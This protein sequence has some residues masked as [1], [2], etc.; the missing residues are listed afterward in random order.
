MNTRTLT[1][2][3]SHSNQS[4]STANE[5][6]KGSETSNNLETKDMVFSGEVVVV[7]FK[8]EKMTSIIGQTSKSSGNIFSSEGYRIDGYHKG[9]IEATTILVTQTG[10]VEG[11]ITA[12]KVIIMGKV[13]GQITSTEEL[14]FASTA[15]VSA[16]VSYKDIVTFRGH[17]YEGTMTRAR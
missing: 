6:S 8:E 2:L 4:V 11:H 14:I 12:K 15:K 17:T 9:D 13:N 5:S 1:A 16:A 10:V 7:K 3:P